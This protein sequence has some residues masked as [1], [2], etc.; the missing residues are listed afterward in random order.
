MI[1]TARAN[2]K[3]VS[4]IVLPKPRFFHTD[5]HKWSIFFDEWTSR[6]K[7]MWH[8]SHRISLNRERFLFA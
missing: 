4:G 8:M 2:Q 6:T 5:A 7:W 3:A 1:P